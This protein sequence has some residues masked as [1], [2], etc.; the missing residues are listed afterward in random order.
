[1]CV[2]FSVYGAVVCLKYDDGDLVFVS[3]SDFDRAFACMI[4]CPKADIIRDF[5]L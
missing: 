3:K 1:M 4:S 5:G 2:G